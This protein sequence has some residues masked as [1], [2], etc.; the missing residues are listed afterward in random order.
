M[1]TRIFIVA[2]AIAL[3]MTCS[4]TWAYFVRIDDLGP[5]APVVTTDLVGNF[6]GTGA[7]TVV[8]A[9]EQVTITGYLPTPTILLPL[10]TS[11]SVTFVE[12]TGP[13]PSDFV[14]LTIGDFQGSQQA[15]FVQFVRI[16]FQSDGATGFAAN[17]ANL[18][19]PQGTV[20]ENGNFQDVINVLGSSPLSVLV[21]SGEETA[22]VPE[23]MS[24]FLFG[25]GLVGTAVIKRR[26][27]RRTT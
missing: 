21:R 6:A 4:T 25:A 7:A 19:N 8:T 20:I 3:T 10:G 1:K 12:P 24:L 18:P 27:E 9:N 22:S 5:G 23:P 14:T 16:F 13:Q 15:G 11:R 17:L 2:L 26:N